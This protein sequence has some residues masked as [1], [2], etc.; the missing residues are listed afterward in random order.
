[1]NNLLSY[2]GLN[3]SRMRASDTDL[4]VIVSGVYIKVSEDRNQYSK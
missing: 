4:P 1:M 3:D 2:F